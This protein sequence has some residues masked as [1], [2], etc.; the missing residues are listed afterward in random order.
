MKYSDKEILLALKS[1]RERDVLKFVYDSH[2]PKVKSFIKHNSG[3]QD[4]AFDIFQ[5]SIMIFYK[6]VKEDRFDPKYDIGAFIFIVSKNLWLNRLRKESRE[7]VLPEHIDFSDPGGNIMDHLITREREEAVAEM[8]AKLGQRCEELLRYSIFYRLK[9]TEICDKMGFST[10]N[11]VKTRKYKC[12]Q[13]LIAFIE[14]RPGLKQTL[15][16]V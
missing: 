16:E 12:M 7:V 14:E 11:A 8:L 15:Q 6:Y 4:A 5:D 9:N 3:D 10:E 2:F 13:K 1:G